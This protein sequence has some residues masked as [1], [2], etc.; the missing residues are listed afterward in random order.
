LNWTVLTLPYPPSSNRY[1]ATRIYQ[2]K[3]TR[4]WLSMTYITDDA[5]AYREQVAWI[6]KAAGIRT[7]IAG[8]YELRVRLYPDRPQDY[9]RR[10]RK[11]G[12]TWD[13]SVR[14]IDL[15]NAEK[16]MSDALNGVAWQDDKLLR[17]YVAERMEPDEHGARLVVWVRPRPAESRQQTI[18][19][20]G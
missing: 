1:W 7:P 15:G 5:R 19:D 10:Q 6:A 8:R 4:Q 14:C 12:E 17:H 16:V 2:D 9:L 3:H 18:L 20:E 11:E 13:D